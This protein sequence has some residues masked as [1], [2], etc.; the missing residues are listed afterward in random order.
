[1]IK[2]KML[3]LSEAQETDMHSKEII[4]LESKWNMYNVALKEEC[5]EKT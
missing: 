5:T 3:F 2:W 4:F 1:M